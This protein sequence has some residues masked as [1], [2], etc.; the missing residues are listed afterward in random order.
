MNFL[1]KSGD[2]DVI[3][4][5]PGSPIK[6]DFN[7]LINITPPRTPTRNNTRKRKPDSSTALTPDEVSIFTDLMNSPH[8]VKKRGK[9]IK[10]ITDEERQKLRKLQKNLW[11]KE[12]RKNRTSQ[13]KEE[14]NKKRRERQKL[15][16]QQEQKK[17]GGKRTR[18]QIKKH[19][20]S[21]Q[22]KKA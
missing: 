10:G 4:I 9:Y 21:R 14:Y 1:N 22:S 17:S 13:E 3:N 18:K 7:S 11:Q 6:S 16:K 5:V 15:K 8:Q 20:K 12:K 2:E 19:K